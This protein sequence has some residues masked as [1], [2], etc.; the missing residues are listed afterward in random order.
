[1]GLFSSPPSPPPTPPPLPAA[2]PQQFAN[3]Q[4][5]RALSGRTDIPW[6]GTAFGYGQRPV[7]TIGQ[8]QT[9]ALGLS[10]VGQPGGAGVPAGAAAATAGKG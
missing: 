1:M 7:S 6:G 5:V 9:A 10:A 3:P 8:A 4:A 2:N